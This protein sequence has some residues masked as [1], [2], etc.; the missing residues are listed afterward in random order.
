MSIGL[1]LRVTYNETCELCDKISHLTKR[2]FAKLYQIG[3]TVGY[4]RAAAELSRMGYHA[5]AKVCMM[6]LKKLK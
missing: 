1:V 5:E 2:F 4:A 3:E 6:E